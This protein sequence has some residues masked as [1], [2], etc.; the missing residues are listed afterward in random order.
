[1]IDFLNELEGQGEIETIVFKHLNDFSNGNN[2]ENTIN[3][4][5]FN[6]RS[7]KKNFDELLVYM[8]ETKINLDVIVLSEVWNIEKVSDFNIPSY[9]IYHNE[10]T[11]NQNDGLIVYIKNS[12]N[13]QVTIHNFTETKV[14]YAILKFNDTSIGLL[15]SYRSP[16]TCEKT[17]LKDLDN[18]FLNL[19]RQDVDIFMGD[20][21]IN[22]KDNINA[23]VTKYLN[24]LSGQGFVSYINKGTRV[25]QNSSTIIDHIFVR[26]RNKNYPNLIFTSSIFETDLTDHYSVF[27]SIKNDGLGTKI[28]NPGESFNKIDFF[29][30]NTLLKKENWGDV[31]NCN[32]VQSS[33]NFFITKLKFY[34]SN[35]TKQCKVSNNRCRKLKPW[36]TTGLIN[37]IHHRDDLKKKL[38]HNYSEEKKEEYV[39][40]RNN[41]NRLLKSTKNNYYKN[42]LNNVHGDCKK[43]WEIINDATNYK[44][45]VKNSRKLN[46]YN[47]SGDLVTNNKENANLFNNYFI[48]VGSKMA[49]EIDKN[50]PD[51]PE[52]SNIQSSIFLK[53]VKKTE[54]ILIISEL[55]SC[56]APGPD[57][58]SASLIKKI[59][60]YIIEPLTFI[61]NLSYKTAILP[62][63]W[64]E[65]VVTPVYKS[66]DTKNR[67]NYRPISVINSFAKILEK[68]LKNRLMS[69]FEKH[70][71]IT[72]KQFGFKKHISTEH[73]VIELIRTIVS[74]MNQKKKCLSIFLDLAKAFDTVSHEILLKRL[75]NVG[76]RGPTLSILANYLSN[77]T[78]RVKVDSSLSESL[79]ITMGV[80]QGTVLGPILFLVYIN[81]I[82]KINLLDGQIISYADDTALVFV[83]DSWDAVYRQAEDGLTKISNWLSYSLLSLNTN[84][85]NFLTFSIS[86]DDQP[87]NQELK[88]HKHN[89]I[90]Q[91]CVCAMI[92]KCKTVKYLGLMIDQHLRW[93]EHIQSITKKVRYLTYKFYQLRYILS[94]NS[95]LTVYSALVESILRYCIIIWG[96]LL[97]NVLKNLQIT[98]NTIL[99]VMFKKHRLY[100]TSALY[101]ESRL[102][103]IRNIYSYNCL[104]WIFNNK[105]YIPV[106]NVYNTR[107]M[108][109]QNIVVPLFRRVHLQ[110]FVFYFA[111]H[112]YN[113]IPLELKII[114]NKNKYKK[115]LKSYILNNPRAFIHLF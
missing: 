103:N 101:T 63:Q 52:G 48:N 39:R 29:K 88:V 64:K 89:C 31:M 105:E 71:I 79:T 21:N 55:K 86:A 92:R 109:N 50:I 60:E 76:V 56:A 20:I 36:I 51:I 40:Y 94:K 72:S 35:A 47:D 32:N 41:L 77:R 59:H 108:S 9:S 68:S 84:K 42:K 102:L 1:M 28:N 2:M 27:L 104:L 43:T 49:E 23:E 34:I 112:L 10:S 99:K 96:G 58:I 87:E 54:I 115:E 33:Y 18:L 44:L 81:D 15:A 45:K 13:A 100:S 24:I 62:W 30:L 67:N 5:H 25:S 74:N 4:I 98:Q 97:D 106:E 37:S 114:R 8:Q 38:M 19:Q 110:R 69:F 80:P 83:G 3:F 90:P 113:I 61:I 107:T 93:N 14:L 57:G 46:I 95:L 11:F 91:N 111:P 65:S 26:N 78:Q 17:Y 66:G 53:P 73:A 82:A 7:I 70:N 6:I 22:I 85:S 75:F 16:S 12:I